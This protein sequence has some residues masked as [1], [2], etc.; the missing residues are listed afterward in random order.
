MDRYYIQETQENCRSFSSRILVMKK[1]KDLKFP[2]DTTAPKTSEIYFVDWEV[3]TKMDTKI[4][5]ITA[6]YGNYEKTCKPFIKQTVKTDFICFTDNPEMESNGWILDTCPYHYMFLHPVYDN[7]NRYVNSLKNNNHSFNIAKY[8]KQA[9]QNI[10]RLKEYDI[11]V[12]VDGTIKITNPKTSEWII[13]KMKTEK[14]IGWNH[15]FRGGVLQRE[16]LA[17]TDNRYSSTH[18]NNQDQPKQ[19]VMFQYNEY[20]KK[21]YDEKYFKKKDKNPNKGVWITCFVAFLNKDA[22]VTRFLNQWYLQTLKYTTQDQVGFS[23]VCQ[24]LGIIPYTLPDEEIKGD[25]PHYYT[26][27]YNKIVHGK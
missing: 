25:K 10:P 12:W 7:V 27:F 9:F 2:E 1:G 3:P 21:G 24:T 15:E 13:E 8:Y 6:I 23:Y 4:C 5:F 26:D 18:W 14:I 16:A 20:I 11:I 17:S 22:E 19:D